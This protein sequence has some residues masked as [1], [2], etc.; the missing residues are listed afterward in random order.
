MINEVY[1]SGETDTYIIGDLQS[2]N[3]FDLFFEISSCYFKI[4]VKIFFFKIRN[5]IEFVGQESVDPREIDVVFVDIEVSGD[6]Q[7][8]DGFS[9]WVV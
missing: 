6:G 4:F 5:L 7:H 2:A 8:R 1:K 3:F 9:V